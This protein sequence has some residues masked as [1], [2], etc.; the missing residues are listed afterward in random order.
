VPCG[1]CPKE[2]LKLAPAPRPRVASIGL[3]HPEDDEFAGF[4]FKIQ[5]NMDPRH[6]DR[7]AFLRVCSGHFTAGM[8]ARLARIGR[9]LR[10]NSPHQFLAQTRTAV[11]EGWPGDVIGI[12]DW[13]TL[14]VGDTV[15]TRQ[16]LEFGE[17]P[18]FAPEHFSR[19]RLADPLRRKQ[20][21][22]GL[23]QLSEEGAVQVLRATTPR[24]PSSLWPPSGNF[25]ST[26]CCIDSS[27]STV[28][29]RGSSRWH[30]GSRAGSR[31]PRPWFE[32]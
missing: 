30:S 23:R 7:M 1:S 15:T 32:R 11:E 6:R 27:A 21:D 19:V 17:F 10:L 28:Y 26:C 14:R 20:L 25:S 3:V 29:R 2:P 18:R 13:G 22:L 8:T 5:A 9:S 4:V 24:A 31:A 12:H 16:G